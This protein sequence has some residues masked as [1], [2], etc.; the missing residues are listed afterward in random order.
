MLDALTELIVAGS[1]VGLE[2]RG[3]YAEQSALWLSEV[4]W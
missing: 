1:V 4:Q 2:A 3:I